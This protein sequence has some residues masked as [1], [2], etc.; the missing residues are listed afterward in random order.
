MSGEYPTGISVIVPCYNAGKYLLPCVQSLVD[1]HFSDAPYEIIVVD[2]R[3]TDETTQLALAR[4]EQDFPQNVIL[5]R[6]KT[7]KGNAA[8]RNAAL[9]CAQYK[10]IVP[11]DADDALTTDWSQQEGQ[12]GYF[13]QAFQ[14]MEA[15]DDLTFVYCTGEFTG[16]KQGLWELPPYSEEKLL[17]RNMIPVFGMFRKSDAMAVG[18]YNEKLNRLVDWEFWI[19]LLNSYVS[20]QKTPNIH[21]IDTPFYLY[22]IHNDSSSVTN[23][24]KFSASILSFYKESF[25]RSP[26]IYLKHI[27]KVGPQIA[28]KLILNGVPLGLERFPLLRR[29]ISSLKNMGRRS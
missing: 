15:S 23:T 29:V 9:D 17:V 27:F 1:Q 10:Y 2:D 14:L 11:I 7:N 24:F 19:A 3:S 5:I 26:N 16:A 13:Q 6:H 12:T 25:R 20:N 8:A 4:L 28:R 18:G 21:R 22:R